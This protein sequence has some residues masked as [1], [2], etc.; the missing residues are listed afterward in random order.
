MHDKMRNSREERS[1]MINF[2]DELS[3]T[4]RDFVAHW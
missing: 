4:R 2:I 3:W 1:Q